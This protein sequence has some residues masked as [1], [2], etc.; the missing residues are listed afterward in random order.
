MPKRIV[1]AALKDPAR[2]HSLVRARLIA[3]ACFMLLALLV[4]L[5]RIGDLQIAQYEAFKTRSHNNRVKIVPV[6]PT[7][8]LIRDRNGVLL[9]HNVPTYTL[10]VVPESVPDLDVMLTGL[11]ELVAL[12]PEGIANFREAFVHQR[13]FDSIALRSRLTEAE[14][15]RFAVNRHRFPGVDVHARLTREYPLGSLAAHLIGYVGRIS[16]A[17]QARLDKT[18]YLGSTYTGKTGIERSYEALLHGQ[19]GYRQV[20]TNAQ[21]RILRVLEQ[22]DPTPGSDL[23]LTVDISLQATAEA[24]MDGRRGALIAADPRTGEILALVSLP[25]YD[26]NLFVHGIARDAYRALRESK[27]RPLFNRALSGRYPPGST[28]KPFFA[29]AALDLETKLG[30]G[31]IRCGGYFQLKGHKHKYRDWKRGGHGRVGL[32]EA[33]SQSCDVYFY[34]LALE[35]GIDRMHA[36]MTK[37]GFGSRTGINLGGESAGLMPSRQW[38]REMRGQIW[39]PGET[40]IVGIGQGFMLATPIQLAMATAALS[41]KGRRIVPQVVSSV[42]FPKQVSRQL[43]K[44]KVLEPIVLS[45]TLHWRAVND[46]MVDVVHGKRGT[47]RSIGATGGAKI[48]GKTG[49]AQ[50]YSVGQEE[51]YDK[52]T[53]IDELRDHGLF[54]AYAPAADPKIVVAVVVEHGGSGSSSAAPVARSVIDAYLGAEPLPAEVGTDTSTAALRLLDAPVLSQVLSGVP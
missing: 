29:L 27:A 5:I 22:T 38:K 2:E 30:T 34:A 10:E 48:A 12:S 41:Q 7:R 54:I 17:E 44:P 46:A 47:A 21:G 40:L 28:V 14:V 36:F 9:A 1:G 3:A 52:D 35:L 16:E 19:V 4:M 50:V 39:F 25:A 31:Q 43:V 24:A 49:T 51:K 33:I 20:E 26:P 15:A 23:N 32:H 42:D 18:N 53:V 13:R 6:P 8:G 11:A 45:N 37:F